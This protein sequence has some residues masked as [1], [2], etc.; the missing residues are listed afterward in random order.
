MTEPKTPRTMTRTAAAKEIGVSYEQVVQLIAEGRLQVV[1][2]G[3]RPR[4]LRE[5]LDQLLALDQA[6][7]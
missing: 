4:V 6:A 2:I 1:E 3:E 5:S 7:S